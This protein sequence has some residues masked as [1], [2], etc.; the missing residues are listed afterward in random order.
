M[1]HRTP[2]LSPLERLAARGWHYVAYT[3][4]FLLSYGGIRIGLGYFPDWL[5]FGVLIASLAKDLYD[6]YRLQQDRQPLAYAGVEHAPSNVVL[7]MF[8]RADIIMPTGTLAEIPASYWAAGL[9]SLDLVFDL[10][11]DLRA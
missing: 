6:E 9:A 2:G 10:S 1:P 8:L 11:Q 3:I 5:L 4:V 7:L